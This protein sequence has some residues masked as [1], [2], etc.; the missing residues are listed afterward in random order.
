MNYKY[1]DIEINYINKFDRE[2]L[3]QNDVNF[4]LSLNLLNAWEKSDNEYERVYKLIQDKSLNII[5]I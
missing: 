3:K 2:L 4:L 1:K 5:S